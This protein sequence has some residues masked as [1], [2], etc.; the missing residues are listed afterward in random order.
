MKLSS[1]SGLHPTS[2]EAAEQVISPPYDVV[3]RTSALKLLKEGHSKFL[4]VVRSDVML[5]IDATEAEV[6]DCS[7]KNFEKLQSDNLLQVCSD[8]RIYVYEIRTAH[9][10][11]TGVAALVSIDDLSTGVIKA[12]ELTRKNKEDERVALAEALGAHTG[13]VLLG[14]RRHESIDAIIE[15][16]RKRTH[17]FSV[18]RADSGITHTV[19]RSS[20]EE[21]VQLTAAF[22][23]NVSSAYIADGHHRAAAAARVGFDRRMIGGTQM[24]RNSDWFT[25]VLFRSDEMVARPYYRR[26]FTSDWFSSSSPDLHPVILKQRPTEDAPRGSAYIL[27]NVEGK[28]EWYSLNL[29]AQ[30]GELDC[31]ILQDQVLKGVFKIEDVRTDQRVGFVGGV[32]LEELE[33]DVRT[34]GGIAFAP[35]AVTMDDVMKVTD[36]GSLMPPKSTWFEPKLASG[37]FVHTF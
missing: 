27:R 25:A 20:A 1:L 33:G 29:N 21:S 7:L 35:G 2:Q 24:E 15:P 3:S 34:K 22:A 30:G 28:V 32:T 14:Y 31:Q 37:F 9:H 12:H 10:V 11:Q 13:P 26:V 4:N 6:H 8:S 18:K 23:A 36:E 19:W 5:P 17:T 16:I